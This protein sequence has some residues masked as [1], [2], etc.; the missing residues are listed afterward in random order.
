MKSQPAALGI[1]RV[2]VYALLVAI[3]ATLLT[4]APGLADWVKDAKD[5]AIKYADDKKDEFVKDQAKAAIL[6]LYKKLYRSSADLA[7]SRTLASVA[8]SAPEL[9][10]LMNDVA[11]AYASGDPEKQREA[12]QKVAVSFGQQLSRLASNSKTRQQ[13]GKIIGSADKVKEVSAVLG[14]VAAGTDAGRRAAAEYVGQVLI[15][16]T[17]G[18]GIVGFYQSAYGAMKYANSEY[19]DSKI[20]DLYR[21]YKNGKL[22]RDGL[23]TQLESGTA[24]YHYVIE[25][26]RKDLEGEKIA[27]IGDAAKAA[28]E[29]VKEHLTKTT[30][31]EVI[32]NITASFDGRI[33]KEKKDAAGKA[34]RDKAQK[35]AE[36]IL[37]ELDWAAKGRHGSDWYEKTPVNLGKFTSV[38][39]DRLK[40]DGVLDP[41]NP[42]HVKLMSKAASVAVIHGNKS[43]AYANVLEE[44]SETRKSILE[45]NKGARCLD[46]S[47]TQA[48]AARLWWKGRQ[49]VAEKK[50]TA[51][52]PLLTQSLEF[53]PDEARAAQLAELTK[54]AKAPTETTTR[55][56]DGTYAGTMGFRVSAKLAIEGS[57]ILTIKNGQVSGTF[58]SR[59]A[60]RVFTDG[61]VTREGTISGRVSEDGHLTATFT[62]KSRVTWTTPLPSGASPGDRPGEAI[63]K[64]QNRALTGTH[65]AFGEMLNNYSLEGTLEGNLADKTASGSLAMRRATGF[66]SKTPM[67]G[68]WEASRK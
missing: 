67:S 43:K 14:N 11:E 1:M 42:L 4:P 45:A 63:S 25:N 59:P 8:I 54:L 56:F 40:A 47:P 29:R 62:G 65:R 16:L 37:A 51:A 18:A 30:D 13:L 36:T 49:L 64:D 55:E 27:G 38:V 39:R 46:G 10:K 6:A 35:E 48:L 9:N 61:V 2:C 34:E 17:P 28:S 57:L 23:I 20:E 7:L 12:A 68:T 19:V 41:N 52:L 26:R 44:L 58:T 33:A 22:S 24:G 32:R 66:V 31:E 21:D 5:A 60:E 3:P 53:C 50:V 15:N